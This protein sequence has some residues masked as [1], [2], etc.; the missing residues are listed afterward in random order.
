MNAAMQVTVRLIRP[1]S[2]IV[3]RAETGNS[4]LVSALL[5]RPSD[6]PV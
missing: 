4:T 3:G 2:V 5:G 1:T 6:S